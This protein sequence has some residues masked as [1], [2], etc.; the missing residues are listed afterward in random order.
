[1]R[2]L[3]RVYVCS[4]LSGLEYTSNIDRA[5]DYSRYIV[6]IGKLPIT[7]HIYFTQFLNDNDEEERKLGM[8][9]GLE[10]LDD[11]DFMYVFGNTITS[12][13]KM[14]IDYW[15]NTKKSEPAYI[16]KFDHNK[17]KPR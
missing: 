8:K 14:E 13:M 11:C 7:P 3:L 4:P 5:K 1:M 9:M 2:N 17:L 12:G 10:L 6:N 15:K 16:K